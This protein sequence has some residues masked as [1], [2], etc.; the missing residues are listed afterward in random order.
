MVGKY[1]PRDLAVSKL[2]LIGVTQLLALSSIPIHLIY[3]SAIFS[4]LDTN[5]YSIVLANE[6]FLNGEPFSSTV[7]IGYGFNRT[8]SS[9]N[10]QLRSIQKLFSENYSNPSI[11]QKLTN[12][13]CIQAYGTEYVAHNNDLVLIT[14]AHG[15]ATSNTVYWDWLGM[16]TAAARHESTYNWMCQHNRD[17]LFSSKCNPSKL[18]QNAGSWTINGYKIDYCLVSVEDRT[19]MQLRR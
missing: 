5:I 6:D 16:L 8:Y 14:S 2:L 7:N 1:S 17:Y 15:N 19:C 4:S 12:A 11:I 9:H 18:K 10:S 13:E 3:N